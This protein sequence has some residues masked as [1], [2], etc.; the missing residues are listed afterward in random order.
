MRSRVLIVAAVFMFMV[1]GCGKKNKKK[2]T[3][4][5]S[6]TIEN[7]TAADKSLEVTK[8]SDGKFSCTYDGVHHGFIMDMPEVTEQAPLVI[9]LHGSG[10]TAEDFRSM[11]HF[12]QAAVPRGYG[13]VYVTGAQDPNDRTAP[14][15]WNSGIGADG[16]DDVG[17]LKALAEYLAQEYSF[18]K[19]RTYA[20]GFSNGAFMT[21]RLAAQA[22]GTFRSVV[23]V[24]GMMPESIWEKRNDLSHCGIFQITGEK[25]DVVPKNSDGSAKFSK[26]PAIEDVMAHWVQVNGLAMTD[27]TLV[28]KG[29]QL[30]KYSADGR[31]EQVWV[32]DVKDGRHSWGDEKIT[33]IDTNSLILDFLDTQ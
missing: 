10:N 33:G 11:T 28:G 8:D 17:F 32:L 14:V 4:A 18:D 29:S 2:V 15:G 31:R 5:D 1:T 27:K 12:E 16:N 26:A 13:V 6:V 22:S 30:T 21:H 25:D 20:V 7:D 3:A 23:S 24:A 19:E 9:M